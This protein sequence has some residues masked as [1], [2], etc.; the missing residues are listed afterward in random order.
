M[1]RGVHR[2]L[3]DVRNGGEPR[4]VAVATAAVRDAKN[5]R[6]LLGPLQNKEGVDVEILSARQEARCSGWQRA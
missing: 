4:V 6:R 3:Q 2:F 1:L 5:S